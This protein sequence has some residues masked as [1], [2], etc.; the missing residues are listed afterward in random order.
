[1][2]DFSGDIHEKDVSKQGL[3][4]VYTMLTIEF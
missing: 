2:K 4:N 3:G 1:M